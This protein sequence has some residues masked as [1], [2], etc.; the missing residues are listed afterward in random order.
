MGEDLLKLDEECYPPRRLF[1]G[2]AKQAQRKRTT[3][4]ADTPSG[5]RSHSTA[6]L[7]L[8]AKLGLPL[9]HAEGVCCHACNNVSCLNPNHLYL[10]DQSSN[11][12]D[13]VAAGTHQA[14]PG[15][16]SSAG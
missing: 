4:K 8:L 12:E 14:G 6:R 1:T 3:V 2:T 15:Q 7:L 16:S 9:H 10:G 13:A 5:Y 11:I